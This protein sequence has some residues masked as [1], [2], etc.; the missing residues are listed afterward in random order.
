VQDL[1]IYYET[2]LIQPSSRGFGRR[3]GSR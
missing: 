3:P 1:V 2:I